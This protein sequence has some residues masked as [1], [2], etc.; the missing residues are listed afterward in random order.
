[1]ARWLVPLL[2]AGCAA[3]ADLGEERRRNLDLLREYIQAGRFPRNE[4]VE[5]ETPIFVDARG[6]PCAV[7]YL[8]LKAGREDL[9]RQ[10]VEDNNYVRIADLR[11]G[12]VL[13]WIRS[14]GLTQEECAAIQPT[15]R[16]RRWRSYA[17]LRWG[18]RPGHFISE[19]WII[20]KE[21]LGRP[22]LSEPARITSHLMHVRSLFDADV[23]M[24]P[25]EE[26]REED[27][28]ERYVE[29]H[30]WLESEAPAEFP[31]PGWRSLLRR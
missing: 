29:P 1:M 14:S 8:M 9:V 23:L 30:P 7:A 6:A 22:K 31:P 25:E 21:Y 24:A 13:D 5:G 18:R 10:V 19:S 28:D 15:Y 26:G 2:L 4:E 11:D 3:P 20:P 27:Q 12:P 17:F 16:W